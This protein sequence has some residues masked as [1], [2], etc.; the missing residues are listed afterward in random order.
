MQTDQPKPVVK[1]TLNWNVHARKFWEIYQLLTEVHGLDAALFQEAGSIRLLLETGG[2][3]LVAKHHGDKIAAGN[4]ISAL[5]AQ[6]ERRITHVTLTKLAIDVNK[7]AREF[8][9]NDYKL[10][11][12]PT[13]CDRDFKTHHGD[14]KVCEVCLAYPM[15]IYYCGPGKAELC[16]VCFQVAS[17]ICSNNASGELLLDEFKQRRRQA[18]T[19]Y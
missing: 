9:V 12:D 3:A 6:L 5:V 16:T 17:G 18:E 11:K 13:L 1:P 10:C 8:H 19:F 15:F 4:I 14:V 7:L 2:A